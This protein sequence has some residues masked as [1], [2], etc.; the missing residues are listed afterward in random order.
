M[1]T[2]FVTLCDHSDYY[3]RALLTLDE[4]RESGGWTGDL[5][6]MAVDFDPAPIPGVE[7]HRISHLSTDALVETYTRFPLTHSHD[8][9]WKTKLYQWDKLQVFTDFF[10]RWE[11]VIFLDAGTRTIASVQPLLDLEWRGALLGPDD[12]DHPSAKGKTF[13]AQIDTVSNPVA[14]RSFL[15][16]FP[17]SIL[18]ASS[19]LLNCMFVV[20]TALL[21]RIPYQELVDAMNTYP[22]ATCNEMTIMNLVFHFRHRVWKPFPTRVGSR[23]LFGWSESNYTDR[24]VRWVDFHF[25]KYPSYTPPRLY[26]HSHML[27]SRYLELCHFQTDIHEHLPTLA[28][29]ASHCRH[30]TE[31]GVRGAISSYALATGIVETAGA[32][33]VQVDPETS[34]ASENFRLECERQGLPVRYYPQSD[35][36]CPMESTDLLFIDTWHVYG[37][38]K[39]ELARWNSSVRKYIILH[40]TEVD[41]WQGET[42]RCGGDSAALSARF[43][44]PQEEICRGLWPAV[45]EFLA[46]H[47]EWALHHHTTRCNG[48]TVLARVP[49]RTGGSPVGLRE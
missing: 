32:R 10:R 35:L 18:D 6:L 7:I 38:L 41:K 21:D 31:C 27:Q 8:L 17:E 23:Y 40:D 22:I 47:P 46:E 36:D 43:G 9:R 33:M 29:Y 44:I 3:R 16:E 2:V 34:L 11:R 49:L 1:S 24:P 4:L 45:R 15:E 48:L 5:V 13:R 20:D 12:T 28:S 14:Y 37:Q 30:I 39:R 19:Y 26:A 42:L 25:M